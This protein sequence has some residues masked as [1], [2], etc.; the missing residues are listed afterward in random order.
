MNKQSF[1]S[2]RQLPASYQASP[3]VDQFRTGAA[4]RGYQGFRSGQVQVPVG[5]LPPGVSGST[6]AP[7]TQLDAATLEQCAGCCLVAWAGQKQDVVAA[8]AAVT[9]TITPNEAFLPFL[10]T[11]PSDIAAFYDV[12]SVLIG[13]DN[14][15]LGGGR[16]NASTWS[17]VATYH[18]INPGCINGATENIQITATN[19]DADPHYFS[20]A[21]AGYF[22]G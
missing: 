15:I 6:C 3:V 2:A 10:L 14:A 7:C 11:I 1:R 21:F 12:T 17:E 8:G 20:A 18:I 9:L 16:I 22:N 5:M 19:F 13:N 4:G